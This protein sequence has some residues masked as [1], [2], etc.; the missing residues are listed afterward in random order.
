M[1]KTT[2]T[3][4]AIEGFQSISKPLVF[5]LDQV[6]LNLIKGSN[7]KGKSTIFN[8]IG[9]AEYGLNPKRSI[10]TWEDKRHPGYRG[11][12]VIVD[13]TVNGHD[14]RVA[15]HLNFKGTTSGLSG[16][17]KLM[18]FKKETTEKS[19]TKDHLMAEGLHKK[20][21][22]LMIEE[23]LGMNDRVFQNSIIFGQRMA[24]LIT[25][26]NTAKRK[27]F[28]E[29]F[30]VAFVEI[31]KETAKQQETTLSSTTATLQAEVDTAKESREASAE[32]L[33]EQELILKN[34]ATDKKNRVAE[35]NRKVDNYT[36]LIETYTKGISAISAKLDAI[37]LDNLK[38]AEEG[39]SAATTALVKATTSVNS[40]KVQISG[41]M[42]E[43]G[44]ASKNVA[45]YTEQKKN[46]DE[47]CFH[48]GQSLE[49]TDKSPEDSK[50]AIDKLIKAEK[51]VIAA[52][53][54]KVELEEK[55]KHKNQLLIKKLTTE[56]EEAQK[57][58]DS[59]ATLVKD[60]ATL[61]ANLKS[62][63]T[64]L[65]QAQVDLGH[66]K[67]TLDREEAVQ[68]PNVDP[69]A[70]KAK[71]AKYDQLIATNEPLI[72]S[73]TEELSR[74]SWWIKTGFSSSGLK[75]FVF[76]AMLT[77][78]NSFCHRYASRLGLSVEFSIDMSKASKPFQTIVYKDGQPRFYEDFSGG[79]MQRI[80]LCIAFAMH[81]LVSIG[82]D[83]NIM[84]A[85]ELFE[86][87]DNEG[88]EV[89]FEFLRMKSEDKAVYLITHNDLIDGMNSR[90]IW[91][92]SDENDNTYIK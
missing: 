90:S 88:V 83:I 20:D 18:I 62:T 38:I 65:K 46:V 81:D 8:A 34:F 7:G 30:D 75:A 31:A 23:Q 51:E 76:N 54:E 4:I 40:S 2:Y 87:L 5:Q 70:T 86:G 14:Y 11:T 27:L 53:Q 48:C 91:V 45:K 52:M 36:G 77:K 80:D 6:G 74:I 49:G 42:D 13:R 55:S 72:V 85:D 26:D 68:K 15:R 56:K 66:A 82:N 12:R 61:E 59:F 79:Q 84:V 35:A 89:A 29:F 28:D 19:F 22:Q 25:M 43:I 33:T 67:T 69:E 71:I 92:D 39:L 9:Y 21:M 78:L 50:K 73:N 24:G 63:S 17:N 37:H 44:K 1:R 32:R 60:K 41:Y 16:G 10:E 57:T 58:V 64:S 47:N 3:K